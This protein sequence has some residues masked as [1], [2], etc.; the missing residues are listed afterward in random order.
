[1]TSLFSQNNYSQLI[2]Q[3][4]S[5]YLYEFKAGRCLR[6][7]QTD[8]VRPDT[9]KGTCFIEQDE[10]DGMAKFCWKPRNANE[11]EES[12]I[13]FPGDIVF[14]KVKESNDRVFVL[15]FFSSPERQ[16]FWIQETD[17]TK[18]SSIAE[19]V[20]RLINGKDMDIDMDDAENVAQSEENPFEEPNAIADI[21]SDVLTS[22]I[23]N[24]NEH[25][26]LAQEASTNL[27]T[28]L[29]TAA[30]GGVPSNMASTSSSRVIH[31]DITPINSL[32]PNFQN[33][34]S[35][36]ENIRIPQSYSNSPLKLNDVIT[37]GVILPLLTDKELCEALF[38][39]LPEG[40][41]KTK[42][43]LE[44][45]IRSPQFDNA[46]QSLSYALESGQMTPLAK[47]LGLP[48][49]SLTSVEGFLLAIKEKAD[50]EKEHENQ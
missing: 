42:E 1:M 9:R 31:D 18:D 10:E 32:K 47:S 34:K 33:L 19:T 17:E 46:I 28:T 48:A 43:E 22:A 4:S 2:N 41:P 16:F 15:K 45:T 39:C 5:N 25:S 21:K 11:A 30:V 23:F 50:K 13:V 27:K 44:N 49:E 37:P 20:T 26:A 24:H 38:P 14:S 35:I 29:S 40:V 6:D 3:A 8:W 12:W 36:I 7:G